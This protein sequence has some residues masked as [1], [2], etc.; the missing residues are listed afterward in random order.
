VSVVAIHWGLI[1]AARERIP[2]EECNAAQND[3]AQECK[4]AKDDGTSQVLS[5]PP[6]PNKGILSAQRSTRPKG[7]HDE[8]ISLYHHD[9][10]APRRIV[11]CATIVFYAYCCDDHFNHKFN[12][13]FVN[14]KSG[15]RTQ[16][17]FCFGVKRFT[18]F[19]E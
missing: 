19:A 14:P 12:H 10:T 4:A 13:K 8:I 15:E 5:R 2:T 17:L 18:C 6:T 7:A 3:A 16:H 11:F 9:K 1:A